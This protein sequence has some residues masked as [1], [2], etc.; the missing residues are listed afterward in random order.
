MSLLRDFADLD[1]DGQSLRYTKGASTR[2]LSTLLSAGP[3]TERA[4]REALADRSYPTVVVTR[5]KRLLG[6]TTFRRD[7]RNWY[8]P[9]GPGAG[10]QGAP[11]WGVVGCLCG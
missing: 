1:P 7:W 4:L 11:P 10:A 3:V 8:A 2:W 5:A 9:T 6:V